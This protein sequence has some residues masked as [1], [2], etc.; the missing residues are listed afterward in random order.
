LR[1]YAKRPSETSVALTIALGSSVAIESA[2][3]P[4]PVPRSSTRG[5]GQRW[6]SSR[7][8]S[9]TRSTRNSVSGRGTS[10]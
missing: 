1:R 7:R 10:T 5:A 8:I 9:S 4:E 6:R 2:I 3:A